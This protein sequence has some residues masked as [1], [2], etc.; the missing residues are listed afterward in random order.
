MQDQ[1]SSPTARAE[2]A[3]LDTF[4][5]ADDSAAGGGQP[6]FAS[7]SAGLIGRSATAA[8]A[9]AVHNDS[10]PGDGLFARKG[11]AAP[12]DL[13]WA[14][15]EAEKDVAIA[16]ERL[17]QGVIAL[18]VVLGEREKALAQARLALEL[19]Q[20]EAERSAETALSHAEEAWKTKE[21][22]RLT[23]LEAEWREKARQGAQEAGATAESVYKARETARIAAVEAEWRERMEKASAAAA[24]TAVAERD[25]V[26]KRDT[27]ALRG[28][29]VSLQKTLGEREAALR[30]AAATPAPSE[31]M[32]QRLKTAVAEA[33]ARWQADEAARLAAAEA[34]WRDQTAIALRDATG[35]VRAAEEGLAKERER[36]RAARETNYLPEV[37]RLR[38]ELAIAKRNIADRDRQLSRLRA[39]VEQGDLSKIVDLETTKAFESTRSMVRFE[40]PKRQR[41]KG[42][43]GGVLIAA[44]L[45]VAAVGITSL[46][47]T[48]TPAAPRAAAPAASPPALPSLA[49][50]PPAQPAAQALA[51]VTG[52]V[53]MRGGPSV[54]TEVIGVLAPGMRVAVIEE[55]G[56]WRRVRFDRIVTDG[57][58]EGWVHRS[59]LDETGVP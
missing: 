39:L 31:D 48:E 59:F 13:S 50:L 14:D 25:E 15:E 29:L 16:F 5:E 40:P 55:S 44:A 36:A 57:P 58:Q 8:H 37:T 9:I 19:A 45:G 4:Y 28:A 11:A 17:R 30:E 33:E 54:Q 26:H 20:N 35:R 42:V 18:T 21:A 49:D 43:L 24:A 41:S 2:Q 10:L 53:N 38:E 56:N 27:D 51:L 23:L 46:F 32:E 3:D 1:M 12:S 22:A 7:L 34:R 52:A 47:E 6:G